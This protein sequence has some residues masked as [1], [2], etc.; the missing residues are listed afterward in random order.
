MYHHNSLLIVLIL[1]VSL[2]LAVEIGTRAGLRFMR[3]T[4]EAAKSQLNSVQASI[5]GVLALLLGF[6]FSLS[7][8][9][10]DT[11]SEAVVNEANAI[12]TAM[13]RADLLAESV[14]DDSKNLLRDYLD[15]RLQAS[16]IS[17]VQDGDRD[18]V[19]R[20]ADAA[21]TA[22]WANAVAASGENPNPVTSGL[23]VQALNDMVD[24]FGSRDAA[25]NRHVP[26]IVLFLMF[27]TLILTAGL[28]GY[29]SGVA[30]HRASFAAYVLLLLIVMMSFLIIDLDRPRR[31]IVE[32]SQKSL[33]DLSNSGPFQAT[34]MQ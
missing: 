16:T 12:G 8:Q 21:F 5:L 15:L 6:T 20:K 25:L 17:L 1:L 31:G 3:A 30:K 32:V 26:E 11:R 27:G 28:V 19:L 22:L 7:L 34:E 10:Y 33:I 24:A 29:S 4:D 2:I 13:L 23:F 9:R 14:R 18:R